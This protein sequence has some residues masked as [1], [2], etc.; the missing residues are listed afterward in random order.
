M[1]DLESEAMKDML[2]S[3][4]FSSKSEMRIHEELRDRCADVCGVQA[5]D[6]SLEVSVFHCRYNAEMSNAQKDRALPQ[7][8]SEKGGNIPRSAK[9]SML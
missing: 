1:G 5:T 3:E 4:S 9:S 7:L 6:T 2:G 8:Y